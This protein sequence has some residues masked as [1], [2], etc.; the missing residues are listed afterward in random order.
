MI[1]G[2]INFGERKRYKCIFDSVDIENMK[3]MLV[4]YYLE[5]KKYLLICKRC[6]KI[7]A[8]CM[9][10][11]GPHNAGWH[12]GKDK[13]WICHQCWYCED[14]FFETESKELSEYMRDVRKQNQDTLRLLR[15]YKLLHPWVKF[16]KI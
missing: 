9:E 11:V 1:I 15:R 7:L 16:K 8:P 13:R 5:R 6:G 2:R 12:K 4:D 14:E 3:D 10:F